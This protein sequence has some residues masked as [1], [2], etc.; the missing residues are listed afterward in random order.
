MDG[1]REPEAAAGMDALLPP[2][3]ALK[4]EAAGVRKAQMDL[5]RLFV[6]A[7]LAGA[8]IALGA[9]FATTA[10]TGA[11]SLPFGLGRVLVGCA[12]ALGL[13]LVI[14]S[15][16]ELFTGNALLVMAWAGGRIGTRA[17]LRNWAVVLAG[18]ACGAIA[19]AWLVAAGAPERVANGELV[20][21]A[22]RVANQKCELG[23]AAA[24]PLGIL[25]NA[26]V[27]LAVWMSLSARSVVDKLAAAVPPVV[28]FVACGFEHSIANLYF[29][30]YA[31]IVAPPGAQVPSAADFLARNLLPVTIGNVLGG[32][33]LVGVVY[34]FVYLR[35][36]TR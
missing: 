15:G 8:F 13:L 29:V 28:A 17:L 23:F 34:W 10:A 5:P 16:A 25:C 36:R 7:V 22:V 18:N 21:T 30:P 31:W 24:L 27:C 19:T 32:G 35:G 3:M 26:L 33:V 9:A 1:S 20:L 6:L 12:F 2:A 14:V 11:G 4:A